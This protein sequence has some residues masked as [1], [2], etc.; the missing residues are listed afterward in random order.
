[1]ACAAPK[2]GPSELLECQS[3]QA[4]TLADKPRKIRKP[5]LPVRKTGSLSYEGEICRNSY[6]PNVVSKNL[7]G[8]QPL[9]LLRVTT[10]KRASL[11]R[12]PMLRVTT[13]A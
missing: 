11:L 2:I 8:P 9:Y 12:K 1:M 3:K 6:V 13:R 5:V 10:A 4:E 7:P